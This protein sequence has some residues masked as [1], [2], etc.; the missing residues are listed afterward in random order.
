MQSNFKTFAQAG[1]PLVQRNSIILV[2]FLVV[3]GL[4]IGTAA[5]GQQLTGTIS[6]TAYDQAG[7]IV[8]NA[9]VEVTNQASGDVRRTVTSSAGF[10]G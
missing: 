5:F 9:K 4:L 3:A 2:V 6:G 10:F 7:A 1:K 8:P